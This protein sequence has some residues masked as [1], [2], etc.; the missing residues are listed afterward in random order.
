M[1]FF[2]FFLFESCGYHV[3]LVLYKSWR[4]LR[5]LYGWCTDV[6]KWLCIW[7]GVCL[8]DKGNLYG[9]HQSGDV[10]TVGPRELSS[11]ASFGLDKP[12][13]F[14]I[15]K[16]KYMPVQLCATRE[17]LQRS[18]FLKFMQ[19]VVLF[20]VRFTHST[21]QWLVNCTK[22]KQNKKIS[23][24]FFFPINSR[25]RQGFLLG[26]VERKK[27]KKKKKFCWCIVPSVLLHSCNV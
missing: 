13:L 17:V 2:F 23:K 18:L 15:Y 4:R 24:F 12:Y 25:W 20:L 6:L 26:K 9:G 8:R 21:H 3:L 10:T 1:F 22:N 16:Y 5:A 14:K 27:K 7:V 11:P 19:V